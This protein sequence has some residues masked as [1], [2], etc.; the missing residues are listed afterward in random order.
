MLQQSKQ[1]NAPLLAAQGQLGSAFTHDGDGVLGGF[2][3][4]AVLDLEREVRA[5]LSRRGEL[6]V[7]AGIFP[8]PGNFN[9]TTAE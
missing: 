6:H 5:D 3:E 4:P 2:L 7:R 1:S 8:E 9:T